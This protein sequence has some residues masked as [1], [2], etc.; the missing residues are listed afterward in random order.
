MILMC[1]K[2]KITIAITNL[3]ILFLKRKYLQ[4]IDQ[5]KY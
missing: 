1:G 2:K 5:I 4:K 3:I